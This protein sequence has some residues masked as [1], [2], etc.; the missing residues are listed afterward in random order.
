MIF[1]TSD[2]HYGHT[3]IIKFCNRPYNSVEEMDESLILNWNQV[4]GSEDH[5][6][7]LGDLA[8]GHN[9][10]ERVPKIRQRLNGKI[11]LVLGN[12]DKKP[13]FYLDAGFDEVVK[14]WDGYIDGYRVFMRHIPPVPD[15]SGR[16]WLT[17]TDIDDDS[18]WAKYDFILSGHV[19]TCWQ[20][21]GK[22]V[23]VGVD[24]WNYRPISMRQI[25]DG[26]EK[27][28]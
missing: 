11:T 23:N 19:H 6:Y 2:T 5:T 10:K 24:V 14:E 25:V 1:L 17:P 7:I 21:K 28:E 9:Q 12:H 13:Q 3:N 26:F 8:M 16:P 27:K 20:Y 18:K 4:V 22:I 15:E